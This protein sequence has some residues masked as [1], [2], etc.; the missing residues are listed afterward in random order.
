MVAHIADHHL[1]PLSLEVGGPFGVTGQDPD[2]DVP[3]DQAADDGGAQ[4]PVPPT[5]RITACRRG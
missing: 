5:T 2:V 3:V 4:A 1:D